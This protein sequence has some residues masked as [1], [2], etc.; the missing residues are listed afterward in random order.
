V[1]GLKQRSVS[2]DGEDQINLAVAKIRQF[3]EEIL[4]RWQRFNPFPPDA[5]AVEKSFQLTGGPPRVGFGSINDNDDFA[6]FHVALR[7]LGAMRNP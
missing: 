7:V 4:S 1:S 6:D 3:P 2:T 5:L